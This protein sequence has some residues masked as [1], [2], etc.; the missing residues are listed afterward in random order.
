MFFNLI[1]SVCVFCFCFFLNYNH[2][3]LFIIYEFFILLIINKFYDNNIRRLNDIIVKQITSSRH[4]HARTHWTI[5]MQ[6]IIKIEQEHRNSS[7]RTQRNQWTW[8]LSSSWPPT[9][10]TALLIIIITIINTINKCAC[11][12][13]TTTTTNHIITLWWWCTAIYNF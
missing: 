1:L 10:T 12:I 13:T 5:F 2:K 6:M 4:D 3:W 9:A 7:L 8:L 11:A